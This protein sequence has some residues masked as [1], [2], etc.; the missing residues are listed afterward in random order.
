MCET[1]QLNWKLPPSNNNTKSN[2]GNGLGKSKKG[3]KK[4]G[5]KSYTLR[6]CSI[7]KRMETEHRKTQ[8]RK[9]GPK[10]RPRPLPMSK[11]RRKTANLRE[12][13]RMGEINVAFENLKAKIPTL[14]VQ[15]KGRC[16]KMTKINVLHVAINYI[17]ALENILDT[18]DAGVNVYG[19]AVVQSASSSYYS[20]ANG[21]SEPESPMNQPATSAAEEEISS[22]KSVVKKLFSSGDSGSE[23]S[24]IM[25]EDDDSVDGEAEA[26]DVECP[27]WT[28]LTS[29]LDFPNNSQQNLAKLNPLK[30]LPPPPTLSRGNLDTLLTVSASPTTPTTPTT[31][32]LLG[33]ILQPKQLNRQTSFPDLGDVGGDDLFSD[34]NDSFE[35]L[36][37]F[38]E[39]IPFN[40]AEIMGDPFQLPIF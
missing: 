7:Q 18:G 26:V 3:S 30:L 40:S 34:L 28:E 13:Q 2:G 25:D 8:P 21:D 10:P 6:A 37:G 38:A 15:G 23:D 5:A 1:L 35:S 36:E 4:K 16:E 33:R 29:T 22:V 17:R 24:G 20:P 27:D 19:T 9:R 14:A 11:Y 12:R 32:A 31:K 39:S